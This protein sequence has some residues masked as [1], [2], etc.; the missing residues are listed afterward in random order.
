MF[1]AIL[2]II[3]AIIGLWLLL[4]ESFYGLGM[5]AELWAILKGVIPLTLLIV[6]VLMVWIEFE[7]IKMERPVK[8]ASRRS[9][10]R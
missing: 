7:E 6:G 4:P 3:V 9:R 1:K 2:G 10:K 5:W 8:T